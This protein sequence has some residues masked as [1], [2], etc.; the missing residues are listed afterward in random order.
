MRLAKGF[1][2]II[3]L[4]AVILGFAF[5][6]NLIKGRIGN[7]PLDL[8]LDKYLIEPE[9]YTE[10][11]I[12]LPFVKDKQPIK[13][14]DLPIPAKEVE[15]SI[16]VEMPGKE[17]VRIIIDKKGDVYKT[18]DTPEDAKISVI[19]WKPKPMGLDLRFGYSLAFS[20]TAYH[21]LSLDYF[22]IKRFSL[23]SE[24]GISTEQTW[25]V[26]LSLKYRFVTLD[27]ITG[28][29]ADA[30]ILGGWNF[31]ANRIY[32]GVNIKW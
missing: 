6:M 13:D 18:K 10:P 32:A 1:L 24:I 12:K 25:L 8:K 11:V 14:K 7:P 2:V 31:I 28:G 26:G 16:A 23:G 20:D 21:C 30:S 15:K 3:G 22:Y 9:T 29:K 19:K 17:P 4:I 27:F 5:I